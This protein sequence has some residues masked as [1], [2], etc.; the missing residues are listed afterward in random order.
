MQCM[1]ACNYVGIQD[2]I[3]QL[4]DFLTVHTRKKICH[5]Y[6]QI[7][8]SVA[9][10]KLRPPREGGPNGTGMYKKIIEK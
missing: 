10:G 5:V 1:Y 2:Q 7:R 9:S 3:N 4:Q 8:L 6:A